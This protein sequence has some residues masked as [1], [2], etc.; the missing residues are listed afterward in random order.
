MRRISPLE[1]D[2]TSSAALLADIHRRIGS[3][4]ESELLRALASVPGQL[5]AFWAAVEP[6][7]NCCV[8]RTAAHSVRSEATRS[9]SRSVHLPDQLAWLSEGG[10]TRE[11]TRQLR[12][13]VEAFHNLEPVFAVLAVLAREWLRDS[14]FGVDL[15]GSECQLSPGPIFTGA[16]LFPGD[17]SQIWRLFPE[18][19]A[20]H[21]QPHPFYKALSTWPR[22]LEKVVSD[23]SNPACSVQFDGAVNSVRGSIGLA[24]PG[25]GDKPAISPTKDAGLAA[26]V[27]RALVKSCE[28]SVLTAALRHS[29]IKGEVSARNRRI[30]ALAE[31]IQMVAHA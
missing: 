17:S 12:Y 29:F 21:T 2:C 25:S 15:G 27:E 24:L 1:I 22:Y 4:V 3:N 28:V 9:A 16:I 20:P 6:A 7:V 5:E 14:G 30:R 10:F 31:P 13:I 23:L 8:L 26:A 18:P 19:D 11:D